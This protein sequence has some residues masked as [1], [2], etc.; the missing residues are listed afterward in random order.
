M[1]H[2]YFED[3]AVWEAQGLYYDDKCATYPLT[4]RCGAVRTGAM[5]SLDGFMDVAF[6]KE[7]VRFT[8]AYRLQQT[9][10]PETIRWESF[11]PALG[12][13]EGTFEVISNKIISC[14]TSENRVY[15]GMET[16]IQ[17][18]DDTYENVGI[19]F[20]NG[21]WMSAWVVT[22]KRV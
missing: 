7:A 3:G 16:L 9:E 5:W 19:S 14:Y 21:Q 4:G 1:A 15:S 17:I 20:Q 10:H 12:K 8:N 22:L 13:L 2:T 6:E 18:D 11:N